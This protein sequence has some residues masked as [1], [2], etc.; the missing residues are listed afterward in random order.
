MNYQRITIELPVLPDE[1]AAYLHKFIE[2]L[3]YAIDEQ[4]YRQIHRYYSNQLTDML[5][6]AQL[7]TTQ[8]TLDDPP[9]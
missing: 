9:F 3:M 8:E 2:A 6:D 1:A 5:K 7:T 4:Y